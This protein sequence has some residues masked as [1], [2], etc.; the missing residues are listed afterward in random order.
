MIGDVGPALPAEVE[1]DRRDVHG[2]RSREPDR[3]QHL[4]LL[5]RDDRDTVPGIAGQLLHGP[6]DSIEEEGEDPERES[7]EAELER[8]AAHPEPAREEEHQ[9]ARRQEDDRREQDQPLREVAQRRL[10]RR[11]RPEQLLAD[12]A[13]VEDRDLVQR[14]D[15]AAGRD[16]EPEERPPEGAGVLVVPLDLPHV[17]H[18]RRDSEQEE[19][20][21]GEPRRQVHLGLE[22]EPA[23]TSDAEIGEEDEEPA[24]QE[25]GRGEDQDVPV[26]DLPRDLVRRGHERDRERTRAP[27]EPARLLLDF[28]LALRLRHQSS[29]VTIL[30]TPSA[31]AGNQRITRGSPPGRSR[32]GEA[33]SRCIRRIASRFISWSSASA[34]GRR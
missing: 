28:L 11:E 17:R 13:L 6:L 10:V 31:T 12:Q 2:H 3:S 33:A 30:T 16:R 14:Q 20:Q 23:Q 22:V 19:Q 24:E 21:P 29:T 27:V 9:E 4:E 8:G 26:D 18:G 1:G 15:E 32:N 34:T 5:L 25:R 7:E